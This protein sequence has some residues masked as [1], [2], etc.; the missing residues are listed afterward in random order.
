M[1]TSYPTEVELS[2]A[3]ESAAGMAIN[4]LFAQH[5]GHYYYLSLITTGEAHSPVLAAWSEEALEEAVKNE[6]DKEDAR[7]GLKWS[8]AD[9]PFYCF[10]EDRFTQVNNLFEKRPDIHSL[11]DNARNAEYELRLRA[12]ES[13][14]AKLDQRG[15][16]GIGEERLK[17][18]VN[19]E[20]MPPDYTNTQRAMRLNPPEAIRTWLEEAAEPV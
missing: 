19:V 9:S 8:Y 16:F 2:C 17:I 6:V 4:D 20:V 11:D 1:N 13:A 3:I 10:G 14:I 12:M 15:I 5:P 18:V 7:Y